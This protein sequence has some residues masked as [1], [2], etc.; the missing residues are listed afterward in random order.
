M[1]D[2]R[3]ILIIITAIITILITGIGTSFSYLNIKKDY[4]GLETTTNIITANINVKYAN[5]KYLEIKNPT[6]GDKY[7][8]TFYISNNSKLNIDVKLNLDDF[9]TTFTNADDITYKIVSNDEEIVTEK[10]LTNSSNFIEN[11]PIG[12]NETREY[13][14]IIT[15]N[16]VDIQEGLEKILTAN[17]KIT[18]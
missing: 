10:Q 13:N 5:S 12:P 2:R 14:L 7:I 6:Q 17:L 1:K 8:K 4:E 15:I 11:L 18:K 3:L 9:R 16:N